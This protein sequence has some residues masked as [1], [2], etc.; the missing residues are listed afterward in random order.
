[1]AEDKATALVAL[2]GDR[3]LQEAERAK[4]LE[5]IAQ[6][7]QG[8]VDARVGT[9]RSLVPAIQDAPQ[10]TV[11]VGEAA[12]A[13]G[14]WRGHRVINDAA[15]EIAKNAVRLLSDIARPRVLVVDNRSLLAD[16]WV[17]R[18]TLETLTR[19]E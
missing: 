13:F 5:A 2:D 3:K 15:D 10:G 19:L 14:P 18:R 16:H 9:L 6:A 4:L 1:M 17:A 12:G 7:R 8:G 11:T